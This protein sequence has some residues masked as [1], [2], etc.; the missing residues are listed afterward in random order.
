MILNHFGEKCLLIKCLFIANV[1]YE[2]VYDTIK[3]KPSVFFTL[4]FKIIYKEKDS[5]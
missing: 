3:Q 2:M 1:M 4:Y 5:Y